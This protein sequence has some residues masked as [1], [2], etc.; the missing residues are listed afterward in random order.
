M[1]EKHRI[2]KRHTAMP[3]EKLAR[4]LGNNSPYPDP[5]VRVF[6]IQYKVRSQPIK[7]AT[8]M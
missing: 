6:A 8:A 7:Q 2:E 4:R 5:S 1:R 3:Q